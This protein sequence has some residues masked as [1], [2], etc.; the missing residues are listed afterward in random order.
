VRLTGLELFQRCAGWAPAVA[1]RSQYQR[2]RS[3]DDCRFSR[4]SG[5]RHSCGPGS[6]C[7]LQA[8]ANTCHE[9]SNQTDGPPTGSSTPRTPG[10]L[11]RTGKKKTDDKH[12]QLENVSS[13]TDQLSAINR[14]YRINDST[15]PK[16]TW[17]KNNNMHTSRQPIRRLELSEEYGGR[18]PEKFNWDDANVLQT[19]VQWPKYSRQ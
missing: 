5:G 15:A 7:R 2:R 18:I 19:V 13:T 9:L 14:Q 4:P 8:R 17:L 16:S 6:C 3:V 10:E 11:S 12:R 1:G